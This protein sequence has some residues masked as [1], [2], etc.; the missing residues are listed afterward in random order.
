MGARM[1]SIHLPG[2]FGSGIA[3]WG[4]KTPEEM[5]AALRAYAARQVEHHQAIIA[6]MDDD[7]RVE[8]YTGVN[9]HRNIDVLQAGRA[10]IAKAQP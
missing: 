10:A 4:R 3:E 1:T 5:I 6:A 8:T 2:L 7:F 9:V